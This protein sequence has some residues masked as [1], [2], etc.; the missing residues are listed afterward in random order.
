[1]EKSFFTRIIQENISLKEA[2]ILD[3]N[4]W[5]SLNSQATA[6]VNSLK[7]GGTIWFCGNGGSAADAQHLAA[8][9]SGR[10]YKNRKAYASEA[11][12]VNSSFM[13]AVA[14]DFGYDHVF[15]RAVEAL[16]RPGDILVLLSTSGNSKNILSAADKAKEKGIRVFA[17]TG[18]SGGL[19][20]AKAHSLLQVP[21]TVTPRIQEAHITLGHIICEYIE[22]EMEK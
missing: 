22:V 10:F 4:I 9:L 18:A 20:A 5:E 6:M 3:N 12:H 13:T 15:A 19:L 17:W 8:E 14:N 11:L 21:S 2:I 1:M 16:V 7:S